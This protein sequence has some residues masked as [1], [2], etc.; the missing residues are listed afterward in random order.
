MFYWSNI[1]T[2]VSLCTHETLS[3]L[4][5]ALWKVSYEAILMKWDAIC[6]ILGMDKFPVKRR[7]VDILLVNTSIMIPFVISIVEM[8]L[9]NWCRF[10]TSVSLRPLCLDSRNIVNS[11]AMLDWALSKL[12]KCSN[13]IKP[14]TVLRGA[15]F[16]NSFSLWHKNANIGCL[17]DVLSAWR[18][19]CALT[20]EN[21]KQGE[22]V[23]R[24]IL[25]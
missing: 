24:T 17:D 20:K 21:L 15:R 10:V 4:S 11:L 5:C 2:L 8:I 13:Q 23:F 14:R 16:I 22:T 25:K 6:P 9:W 1:H 3:N 12:A 7:I 19:P 18:W